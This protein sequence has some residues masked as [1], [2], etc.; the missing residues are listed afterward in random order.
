[1]H[2]LLTAAG[3][4]CELAGAK[5]KAL[6]NMSGHESAGL[7]LDRY[8]HLYDSDVDAVGL[9]VNAL[10][11]RGCVQNVSAASTT[12]VVNLELNTA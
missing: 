2:G 11:T 7:T 4:D 3:E 8:G 1:V 12:P 10:L 6:Q 9:A 5:I